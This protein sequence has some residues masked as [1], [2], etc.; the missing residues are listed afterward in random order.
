[1]ETNDLK[2]SKVLKQKRIPIV[3][4]VV[5]S[6]TL[7][8]RLPNTLA[9]SM[10]LQAGRRNHPKWLKNYHTWKIPKSWFKD[11]V[12]KSLDKYRQVYVVQPYRV[13][14]KCCPSC[15]NAKGIECV[16]SCQGNNHGSG[17]PIG[18][19]HIVSETF[20]FKWEDEQYSCRLVLPFK[21]L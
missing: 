17:Q 21:P 18:R 15:W 9:S 20:A 6:R 14:Q 19:W 12:I 5:K 8:V 1:M 11:I 2:F 13:M 7:M 10:W 16:C 3:F 4:H